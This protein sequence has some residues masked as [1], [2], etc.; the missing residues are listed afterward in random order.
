MRMNN[1]RLYVKVMHLVVN[2]EHTRLWKRE[3]EE[4][5]KPANVGVS[6]TDDRKNRVLHRD[7]VIINK[8]APQFSFR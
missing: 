8:Y 4:M 3:L 6:I 1:C 5:D 2:E 7:E